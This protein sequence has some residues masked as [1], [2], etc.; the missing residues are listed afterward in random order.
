MK[1]M[2][3]SLCQAGDYLGACGEFMSLTCRRKTVSKLSDS[4]CWLP[5][6]RYEK[7]LPKNEETGLPKFS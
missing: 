4:R 2:C 3:V 5:P 7:A 6:L 1:L